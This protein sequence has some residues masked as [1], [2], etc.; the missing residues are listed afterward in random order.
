MASKLPPGAD[1]SMFK[2]GIFPD[3][4]DPRNQDGGRWV[5]AMDK[6]KRDLLDT[7]WLEIMFFLIGEHAD[8]HAYQ[9]EIVFIQIYVVPDLNPFRCPGQ[10]STSG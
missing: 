3:W 9:V 8:Q 2:E 10:L 4:E 5:I 6:R 7:Y 1:Y